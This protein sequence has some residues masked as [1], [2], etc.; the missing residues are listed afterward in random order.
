MKKLLLGLAAIPLL[1]FLVVALHPSISFGD[2]RLLLRHGNLASAVVAQDLCYGVFLQGR[3]EADVRS[4]E[5]GPMLDPRLSWVR[6]R[7][8]R[9]RGEVRTRVWGLFFPQVA[10]VRADGSC[11]TG[12]RGA[13]TRNAGPLPREPFAA[14]PRL[15]PEG[16]APAPNA[17]EL[18]SDWDAL[19]EAVEAEFRPFPSGAERGTRSVL[20]FH[21][22]QFVYERHAEGWDRMVPQN[23][24][25]LTK[26]L[27][28][29]LAGKLAVEGGLALDDAELRPEWNDDRAR[30][31]VRHLLTMQSG[32]AWNEDAMAG[33]PGEAT[34]L[35]PSAADY[36]AEKPLDTEP[37]A[38]F[39]YSGGTA[40][41]LMAVLE[42][43]SG[44]DREAW[45]RFPREALFQP[46]GMRHVVIDR[47]T[48]GQ[49]IGS[50]GMHASATD[51]A[52]LGLFLAQD[53]V[54]QGERI[55]PEGW[56]EFM[57]TPTEASRCN[58]G[59]MLW[60]RGGCTGGSPSPVFELS[61]F[62]GQGVTVVPDSETIVVR[63][64]FG[65]WVQGDLLERVFPALGVEAPTRMAMEG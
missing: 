48:E 18:V 25:S 41:L 1:A 8:D 2:L 47:D 4:A 51:W 35:A 15:W 11:S 22:G 42:S 45:L 17:R 14:D 27:A 62:M 21:R 34:L 24:R 60:I 26:A 10:A 19:V 37:G 23:G 50:S 5:L 36:A 65:P 33:D 40:E 32:L 7:V 28:A 58:Y 12:I 54:W 55:L 20:V 57:I 64:G 44:L 29:V 39:L 13:E 53:G 43:R 61:G 9:D 49:F 56:V 16:D 3:T 52:R 46:I 38:R 59:A 63:L 6:A 30:I 31:Q